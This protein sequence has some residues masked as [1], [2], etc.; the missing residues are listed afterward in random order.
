MAPTTSTSAQCP[1]FPSY[2]CLRYIALT[3]STPAQQSTFPS[4][5]CLRYI[6]MTTST[7]AQHSLLQHARGTRRWQPPHL[8]NLPLLSH[9]NCLN[10]SHPKGSCVSNKNPA[11][12]VVFLVDS[13]SLCFCVFVCVLFVLFVLISCGQPNNLCVSDN[14]LA[15]WAVFLMS[16][17]P[18]SAFPTI[19]LHCGLCFWCP[20]YLSLRF[21]Q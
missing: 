8:P 20:T 9:S 15:L 11:L 14:N 2:P 18:T 12:W 13:L 6:V 1:T 5:P 16:S 10:S 17:L 19:I 3:T 7:P 21:Q 4:Y